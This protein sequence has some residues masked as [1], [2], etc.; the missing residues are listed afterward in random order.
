MQPNITPTSLQVIEL[1]YL[2]LL[3]ITL[4]SF[5]KPSIPTRKNLSDAYGV[6]KVHVV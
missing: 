4:A 3:N 1:D 5:L 2:K 6:K